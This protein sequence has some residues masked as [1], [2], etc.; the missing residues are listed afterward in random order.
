MRRVSFA[1][2]PEL[3]EPTGVLASPARSTDRI[4]RGWE[5]NAWV[6]HRC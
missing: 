2:R 6:R 4:A 3:D 1:E 5:P